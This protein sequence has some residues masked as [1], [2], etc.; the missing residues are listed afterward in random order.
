MTKLNDWLTLLTNAAV[1]AGI[2]FLAMEIQQN[3]ELLRSETRLALHGNDQTSLLVALD[4]VD[5]F[6][7]MSQKERLSQSD[8]YRLSWIYANDMRNREFEFF[9]YQ[10]GFLDEETWRSYRSLILANHSTP[11]GRLWWDKLGRHATNPGFAEM[12]DEM[13]KNAP[14]DNLYEI[15]GSWDEGMEQ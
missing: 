5:I 10:N 8:Q 6:H 12:V 13:L 4:N 14:V 9:Q 11:R 1:V 3:N 2:V 15:A 7:K